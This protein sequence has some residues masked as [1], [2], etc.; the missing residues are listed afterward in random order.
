MTSSSPPTRR[1]VDIIEL[2]AERRGST[3]RLSDI[4]HTLGLNQATA[5][6]ILKELDE[7]GWV[8]R[9]P[10]DKTFS[11]GAALV[12]LA[13]R[14]DQSP[15]IAHAARAAAS[16]AAADTGYAT[17]VSERVGDSLVITAFIAGCDDQWSLS[18]GDRLPFAAPFGP[19]YAAWEPADERRVWIERSGVNS[20]AF[21]A[22]LEEHL[23]ETRNQGF[24]VERMSP[25]IA[26]A[27]PVMTR[28]QMDARSDS[29]RDHLNEV[30]LEITC[31]P[32]VSGK[33]G[34]RQ[35]EYV[36]AVTAPIFDQVGRVTHNICVH[37]FRSLSSR[38]VEQIGRRL[39]RA[40]RAVGTQAG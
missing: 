22:R 36:G 27:V 16:A 28:L 30:L 20:P 2:L 14:I 19:A 18:T 23:E 17:S 34:S 10:A 7:K 40:A 13:G 1:V 39:R 33:P 29:V 4:V 9:N 31:A 37:P 12:R 3:T 26:S 35:R 5:Y 32:R 25:D 21:Q 11:V 8:T 15:S 24:S 6:V 38:D